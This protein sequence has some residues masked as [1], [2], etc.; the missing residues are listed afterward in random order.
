[1]GIIIRPTIAP[2]QIKNSMASMVL[3]Y[4]F[5]FRTCVSKSRADRNEAIK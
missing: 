5:E 3:S 2:M 4:K 1:M